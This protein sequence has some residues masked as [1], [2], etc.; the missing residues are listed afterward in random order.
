[1]MDKSKSLT[2]FFVVL[3]VIFVGSFVAAYAS[4]ATANASASTN[5]GNCA[6]EVTNYDNQQGAAQF[7]LL[8]LLQR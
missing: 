7:F 8:L 6:R 1:M 2:V 5:G 4:Y 3:T